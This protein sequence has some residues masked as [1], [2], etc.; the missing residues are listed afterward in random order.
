MA[1]CRSVHF[2]LIALWGRFGR[3]DA[4]CGTVRE[5]GGTTMARRERMQLKTREQ[6]AALSLHQK[7]DYLQTV[8]Q[9]VA[10]IRDEPFQALDRD[11]LSRLRRFYSRR[12]LADL[13]LE[14][15]EEGD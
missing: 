9:Q 8:A 5:N 1:F 14:T 3:A 7:N 4:F 2:S 12:S 11:A 15:M 6:F 10:H 13:R